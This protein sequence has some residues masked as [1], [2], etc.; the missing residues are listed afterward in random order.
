MDIS[1][2][3]LIGLTSIALTVTP[4]AASG[5]GD[6]DL[7]EIPGDVCITS[8]YYT[9]DN[10]S[11]FQ[12]VGDGMINAASAA[13]PVGIGVTVKAILVNPINARDDISIKSPQ[14]NIICRVA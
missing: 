9:V 7:P 6:G 1:S 12:A 10:D 4:S 2:L 3:A 11:I 14:N 5:D 8:P 13:L